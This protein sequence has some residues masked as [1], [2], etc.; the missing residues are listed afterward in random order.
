MQPRTFSFTGV[1][2]PADA[3][4]MLVRIRFA[5]CL[6]RQSALEGDDPEALHDFRLA[7]KRLRF[8]I[9]RY[10]QL[11][12]SLH[13]AAAL[14]SNITDEVGAAHDCVVL[15][16]RAQTCGAQAVR[17]L[18]LVESIRQANRARDIW[19][20]GFMSGNAFE[21]LARFAQFRWDLP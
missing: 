17:R 20:G 19:R 6:E 12:P 7:C 5:E 14:L 21:P 2:T 18:A 11:E 15:A 10:P 8:A 13:L 1:Q 3:Q 16:K 4:R 9:E